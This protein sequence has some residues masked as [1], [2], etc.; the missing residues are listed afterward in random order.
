MKGEEIWY[1]ILDLAV[2]ENCYTPKFEGKGEQRE[3]TQ[4]QDTQTCFKSP[5]RP[6]TFSGKPN[7]EAG[8]HKPPIHPPPVL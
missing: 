4:T 3:V 5:C 8:K 2:A 1:D 6:A 7:G